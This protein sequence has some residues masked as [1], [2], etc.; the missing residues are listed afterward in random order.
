M[1][2]KKKIGIDE[3]RFLVYSETNPFDINSAEEFHMRLHLSKATVASILIIEQDIM[4]MTKRNCAMSP[5]TLFLIAIRFYATGF[6][7]VVMCQGII[8]FRNGLLH[9]LFIWCIVV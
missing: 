4:S 5:I 8:M 1:Q 3:E 7:F 9:V 2:L 6:F